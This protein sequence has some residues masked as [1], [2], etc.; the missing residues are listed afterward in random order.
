MGLFYYAGHG[1][2]VQGHNYLVPIGAQ[3]ES[4]S[5]VEYEAVDAGRVLGKMED[6]GNDLN[7]VFLDACRD[8]P[9]GRGFRT[10]TRGL[11]RMDAPK[12]SI[13]QL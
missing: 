8:N 5:D 3:I 9:F 11:A 4:A 2:Q 12:G 10:S 13:V 6:A 7:I 1:L